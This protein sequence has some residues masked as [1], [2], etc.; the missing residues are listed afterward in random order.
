MIATM[1]AAGISAPLRPDEAGAIE[2][3]V[4]VVGAGP[5]G[6]A[7]AIRLARGGRGGYCGIVQLED[8]RIDGTA[9]IDRQL[10]ATAGGSGPAAAM[11]L[12]QAAG[13][14]AWAWRAGDAFAAELFQATP[15][16]TR[17]A[18]PVAGLARQ[19]H[20]RCRRIA[21]VLRHPWLVGTAIRVAAV[22]P[23]MAEP[24][25]PLLVGSH[26]GLEV[27]SA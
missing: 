16:L 14:A 25:L 10:V 3:Q 8:G 20:R 13:D 11:I 7:A 12:R 26:R 5:A 15:P 22:A 27:C 21:A 2:W 4:I 1:A 9:A 17:S 6:A 24:F 19:H 18:A 23:W